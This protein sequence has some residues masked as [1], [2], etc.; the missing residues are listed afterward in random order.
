[1]HIP[2]HILKICLFFPILYLMYKRF[3]NLVLLHS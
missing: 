1:M 3:F 2:V